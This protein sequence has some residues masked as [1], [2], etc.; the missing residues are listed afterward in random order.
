MDSIKP[1]KTIS[2]FSGAGGGSLG[3]Y[4]AGIDIINAYDNSEA[5]VNTYNA[6]F[7]GDKC[8]LLDLSSCDFEA[9]RKELGLKR[10]ELDI[11]TGGPPC[12]GFTTAG[13]R[14]WDDPRNRLVRNYTQAIELFFPRWFM[15]ENVEG[16]LTTANG[17][18]LIECIKR[19][20]EIGY[21]IFLKKVYMQEYG[22]PQRRKRVIIVGNRMGIDY[23]FPQPEATATG[24][25]YRNSNA[26]LRGAISDLEAQEDT[27]IDH[28]FRKQTAIQQKRI[29]AL[30]CGQTMKDLPKQLQH[31]SF[32]RRA[33]R[34]VC[35]GTPAEKRGGAPSGLKRL[36]YDEPCLTITSASPNEFVHPTQNR[37]LT[38]RECARIQT[39]P[40]SFSFCGTD[41]Q[42]IQ[43]IGNAIPPLFAKQMAYSI[44]EQ[45]ANSA[46]GVV[47]PG[48]I[49]F[50]VTK[51]SALSPALARTVRRLTILQVPKKE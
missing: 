33:N 50:E 10:G 48:L 6:N 26:T 35:D 40:D 3:F 18:Y 24:T 21:S 27:S 19:L 1:L 7:K 31:D 36:Y 13:T 25:I 51:A 49:D 22:I 28:I 39:F 2:L 5:A 42:K 17:D 4:E 38:L 45:D 8:K 23:A 32:R 30:K 46:C 44:I 14:F 9:L 11:I 15:M 43:Q 41:A 34:R 16:I 12:Q 37:T 29:A 20:T 47:E